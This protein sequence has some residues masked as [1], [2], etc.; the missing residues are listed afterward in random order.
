RCALLGPDTGRSFACSSFN[1][2][3]LYLRDPRCTDCATPPLPNPACDPTLHK[4][5]TAFRMT[6]VINCTTGLGMFYEGSK[7]AAWLRCVEGLWMQNE[8]VVRDTT[9][10]Y[11]KNCVDVPIDT[12]SYKGDGVLPVR[13]SDGLSYSCP[14][15]YTRVALRYKPA[16]HSGDWY[17]RDTTKFQCDP[18]VGY[19]WSTPGSDNGPMKTATIADF[20][21]DGI[22]YNIGCF[23]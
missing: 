14:A 16:G 23:V 4:C 2:A 7:S 18:S 12:A 8:V 17:W 3:P 9:P 6:T 11:C 22:K 21:A 5:S 19:A 1:G 13:S 20:I 10:V 15:P